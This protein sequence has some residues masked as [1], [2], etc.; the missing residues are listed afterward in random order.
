MQIELRPV[1]G[2]DGPDVYA[3][4]QEMPADEN[5]FQNGGHG[6]NE[7][8]YRAWLTKSAAMALGTGLEDWQV[9]FRIELEQAGRQS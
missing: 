8:G 7:E 5:G 9:Y 4:L 1:T 2:T 6:L 3:M